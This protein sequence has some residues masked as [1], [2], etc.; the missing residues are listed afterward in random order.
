MAIL[1]DDISINTMVGSGAFVFGNLSVD[2]FVRIDGSVD[3]NLET[4]GGAIIGEN[5]KI[6][7]NITAKSVIIGG[8]IE[9][10]VVAPEGVHLFSSAVIFGDVISRKIKVDQNVIVQGYMIS[11][12]DEQKFEE[13]KKQWADR[14]AIAD[15]N[16]FGKLR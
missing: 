3:G 13:A 16:V 1:S 6:R 15:K 7:G 5:A 2:G 4:T 11:V 9:G 10:D 14:R 8:I 12:E